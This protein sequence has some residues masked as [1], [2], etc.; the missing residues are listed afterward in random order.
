MFS[1]HDKAQLTDPC[2]K[3]QEEVSFYHGLEQN[4]PNSSFLKKILLHSMQMK[5]FSKLDCFW[6]SSLTNSTSN[7]FSLE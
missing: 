6:N 1:G 3:A 7:P 5:H 2:G 4:L